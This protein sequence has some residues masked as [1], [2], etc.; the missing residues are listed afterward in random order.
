MYRKNTFANQLKTFE[1]SVAHIFMRMQTQASLHPADTSGKPHKRCL[2][3]AFPRRAKSQST[4]TTR[5]L[6]KSFVVIG[7]LF[8]FNSYFQIE[9][10]LEFLAFLICYIIFKTHYLLS[11]SWFVWFV[12]MR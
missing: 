8:K 4:V 10:I 12:L 2:I 3:A 9:Q 1:F 5:S 7:R 11:V 6:P